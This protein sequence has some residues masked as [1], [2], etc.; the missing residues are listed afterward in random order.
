M[1]HVVPIFIHFLD[2]INGT[3][4]STSTQQYPD[5]IT[6]IQLSYTNTVTVLNR[7]LDLAYLRLLTSAVVL[8][9]INI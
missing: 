1:S 9:T 6:C 3:L 8:L 5:Q 4:C 2:S 7:L